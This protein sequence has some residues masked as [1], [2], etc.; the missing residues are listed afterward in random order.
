MATLPRAFLRYRASLLLP[1]LVLSRNPQAHSTQSDEKAPKRRVCKA[2]RNQTWLLSGYLLFRDFCL[3]HLEEAKPLVEFYEEVRWARSTEITVHKHLALSEA[4]ASSFMPWPQTIICGCSFHQIK[5]Y[6]KLETEEERVVRSREI[7][8]SYIMK[9]LL[10]C[11][12]VSVL[13]SCFGV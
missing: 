2:Q 7:F 8:D 13:V 6:E 9:E 4:P 10:A 11:S 12:H 1:W 3:N 5:K